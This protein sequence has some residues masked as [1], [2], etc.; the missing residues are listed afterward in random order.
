MLSLTDSDIP[1]AWSVYLPAA[2]RTSPIPPPTFLQFRHFKINPLLDL[3]SH[4]RARAF[5]CTLVEQTASKC[6]IFHT[7][8]RLPPRCSPNCHWR[9]FKA[10]PERNRPGDGDFATVSRDYDP[11]RWSWNISNAEFSAGHF[12]GH[13][14]KKSAIFFS[15]FPQQTAELT[16]KARVLA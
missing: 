1:T 12:L 9:S 4:A 15:H 3:P 16:K 14:E 5:I 8:C 11:P 10:R 2:S 13:I 7:G 6:H